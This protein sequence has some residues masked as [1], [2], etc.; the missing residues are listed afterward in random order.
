MLKIRSSVVPSCRFSPFTVVVTVS[1]LGRCSL[2][3]AIGPMGAKVSGLQ[4]V[5]SVH[6]V[7]DWQ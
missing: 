1:T 5:V 7:P 4:M 2:G 6:G 3:T